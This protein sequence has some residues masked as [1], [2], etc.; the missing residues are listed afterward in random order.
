MLSVVN[1]EKNI[2]IFNL[3]CSVLSFVA[4]LWCLLLVFTKNRNDPKKLQNEPKRAKISK[5][6][7]YGIFCQLL[8][9]KFRAQ[10]PKFGYLG[11]K[12]FQL[13][14]LLTKFCLKPILQVLI[15]NLTLVLE[16]FE[17]KFRKFGH[18]GPNSI[19]F[20]ILTKFRMYPFRRY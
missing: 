5:L 3:I 12:K 1:V 9:F 15:L 4:F 8:F 19:N 13:S 16:N 17:S 7:K 20:Q 14:N 11:P 10:M 2:L 18:F 6:R